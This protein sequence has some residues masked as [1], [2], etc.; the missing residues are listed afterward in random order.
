MSLLVVGVSHRRA[1]VEALERVA[2]A[3]E[4]LP[5]A[6]R[7]L[8][9]SPSVRE[10][11]ILSTC[12]RVEIAADVDAYHAG[13]RD[14]TRCLGGSGSVSEDELSPLLHI[15]YE[16]EAVRY[17]FAVAAGLDSMVLGEPQI[18]GQ[19]RTALRDAEAEGAAGPALA[20]LVRAAV[21]CG[22]RVRAETEIGAS[23]MAMVEAGADLAERALG[24]LEGRL[25]T[26]VGAGDMA[27]LAV[28]HLRERG[29]GTVRV[30]N[31]STTRA[32]ALAARTGAE[33]H[34]L[35]ALSRALLDADLVVACT[36]AAGIVV[37]E[38]DVRGA[39]EGRDA[40]R[41]LFLL[42]LAV[43]RDVDPAVRSLPG[44]VV[45]DLDDLAEA[46]EG[47]GHVAETRRAEVIV[48]QEAHRF[49]A[50]RQADRLAPV[51]RGIREAGEQARSAEVGR[52]SSR[53]SGLSAKEREAVE[54]M[55]R[56]IVAKL[57]HGPLVRLGGSAGT[58]AGDGLAQ[59]AAELFGVEL[60]PDES[61]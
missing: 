5:K 18:L 8:F 39:I 32:R 14:L 50:R 35:D 31:R 20:A 6:F 41:P 12:N 30:A 22:R 34:G 15:R 26:V 29:V 53:L 3:Q 44:A 19:V 25:V 36:G 2:V 11:M 24:G 40:D 16:G 47:R 46:L 58:A 55:S 17:L 52:Y 23:P 60:E 57:L 54:A 48:E 28:R 13:V 4:D 7:R 51:I 1:P 27:A 59:A 61:S 43:P 49:A 38:R 10:A 21:R 9:D 33:P 37:D 56:G 45:A 42:D